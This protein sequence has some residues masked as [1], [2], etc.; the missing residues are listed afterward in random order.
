MPSHANPVNWFEI[1]VNDLGKAKTFYE[2]V[3]GIEITESEMGPKKMGF[4]P[5]EMGGC[6]LNRCTHQR[7]RL[8]TIARRV[9]RLHPRR[10]D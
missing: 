10:P 3:L 5:M 1:P 8:Q 6:R 4:F 7:R 9:A 2:S